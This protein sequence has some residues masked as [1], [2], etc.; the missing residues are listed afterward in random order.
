LNKR[1]I[2]LESN[3]NAIALFIDGVVLRAGYAKEVFKRAIW[4]ENANITDLY[5]PGLVRLRKT[6]VG[7]GDV[8]GIA[9]L[10][11]CELFRIYVL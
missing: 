8:Q 10:R 1:L 7:F 4:S 3:R 11:V 5:A 2:D 6:V 9:T